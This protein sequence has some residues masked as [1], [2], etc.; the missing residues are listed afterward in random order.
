MVDVNRWKEPA[1]VVGLAV[2][3]LLLFVWLFPRQ[4]A[5]SGLGQMTD[6]SQ[7]FD[8]ALRLARQKL[9]SGDF[10]NSYDL[11]LVA[12][13]LRPSDPQLLDLVLSF[14][15]KSSSSKNEE[16][17]LLADDLISR[18]ESLIYFQPPKDVEAARRRFTEVARLHALPIS[19]VEQ[20]G[21]PFSEVL[22]LLAVAEKSAIPV[23]VR[24]RA[25][26]QAR[27]E[28]G[29]LLLGQA[30]AGDGGARKIDEAEAERIQKRIDAAEQACI[31]V[32]FVKT[33]ERAGTWLSN[34]TKLLEES[35]AANADET[36]GIISKFSKSIHTGFDLVQE[37]TPYGKSDVPEAAD[38]GK[39]VEERVTLLQR[40]K[41]W[42]YNQQVLRLIRDIEARK[43]M[44]VQD[45]I[46]HLA[47]VGEEYLSP[48]VLRRHN[49]LWEK[50]FEELT[51]EDEKVWA[52]RLRILKVKE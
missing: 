2:L 22:G 32:V 4:R 23:S 34:T 39:S 21:S 14:I 44:T 33:K 48:Y 1:V 50:V 45:K 19:P 42:L 43:D 41:E 11:I 52:V 20:A 24:N 25:A 27:S 8:E 46:R 3:V 7:Q 15:K 16:V 40:T 17:A 36:P 47:E 9:E 49:E 31:G 28:L 51:D 35:K 12:S 30:V 13:R 5:D 18:G 29:A 37:L 6:E 10:L 26:E 38:L